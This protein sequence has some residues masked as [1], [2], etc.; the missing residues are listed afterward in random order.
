M[1]LV[2]RLRDAQL[3]LK[4]RGTNVC[5]DSNVSQSVKQLSESMSVLL[6]TDRDRDS[7]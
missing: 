3:S 4:W 7:C 6:V 5:T 1:R 2:E